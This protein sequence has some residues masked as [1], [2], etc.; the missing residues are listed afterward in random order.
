[1][2][3]SINRRVLLGSAVGAGL[4][5]SFARGPVRAADLPAVTLTGGE[6]TLGESTVA[7]FAK[8]LAGKVLRAGDADYDAARKIWNAMFDRRPALIARCAS[9]ADVVTAVKFARDH[10]LLTAVRC[11]GHSISGQ[12]VVERGLVIDLTPLNTVSLDAAAKTVKVGGGCLL[13]DVDRAAQKAGLASTFGVVSHTGVGGLTLG[14]GM[15]RLQRQFGMAVD[16][17]LEVELVTADGRVVTANAQQNQDLYWGVRGGGGNFG[18][19]TMFKFRL[20]DYAYPV[21]TQ[22]FSFAQADAKTVIRNYFDYGHTKAPD[23]LWLTCNLNAN[24]KGEVTASVSGSYLGSP[25]D[26]EKTLAVLGG[27]A[28]A[29]GTRSNTMTYVDLQSSIDKFTMPGEF[30]YAKGGMLGGDEA[31]TGPALIDAMFDYYVANPKPGTHATLLLMGGAINR[32]AADATAYPHRAAMHNIDVGGEGT[33]MAEGESVRDWGRAFWARLEKFSGNSFYVN[34]LMDDS[35]ARVQ[36]NYGPNY[37][38]LVALKTK[39]DP[40]NF[41]RLNANIKPKVT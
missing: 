1:M 15:G 40:A 27:F 8:S 24:A 29:T 23:Q 9:T 2:I 18:I 32:V 38:R 22:S 35:A 20:H 21:M 31:S 14:G 10:N 11:G 3:R 17:L 34:S 28:K 6:A 25:T 26:A 30:H 41:F 16:N 39:Y 19:V 36:G 33:T 13:G 5:V 37:E 7:A 4:T 12:S